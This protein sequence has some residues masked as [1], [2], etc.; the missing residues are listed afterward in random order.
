MITLEN[1]SGF[2][3]EDLKIIKFE[4]VSDFGKNNIEAALDHFEDIQSDDVS[5]IIYTSG[6]GGRPKG[7]MLTHRNIFSNLQGAEDLL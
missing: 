5:C 7:V 1:Y 3:P 6:T 2:E 4:E